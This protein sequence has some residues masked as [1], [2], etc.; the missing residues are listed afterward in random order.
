MTLE[1]T[2]GLAA[3]ICAGTYLFGFAFLI[4]WL[5]P[6]GFGTPTI[7][8]AAVVQFTAQQPGLMVLFN[9]VIYILNGFALAVLVV[10][11]HTSLRVQ[12]PAWAAVTQGI[13]FIWVGLVLG[14]GMIANVAVE[15]VSGLAAADPVGAAELWR[16]LRAVE[17]GLG[18]GNEI[19]G[20]VWILCV[21]GVAYKSGN[22]GLL[23]AGLGSITGLGGALTLIPSIGETAGVVFGLGGILWFVA[24]GVR[25][26]RTARRPV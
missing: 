21:S 23:T 15:E 12:A 8:A 3:L 24:V 11:L 1:K 4:K 2:G 9:S 17:L 26:F 6:L 22:F 10:A 18:G 7:D 14:A 19:V 5:V 16:I 25:L 20:G 13:G